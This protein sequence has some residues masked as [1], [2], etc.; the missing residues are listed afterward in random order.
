[1]KNTKLLLQN[2]AQKGLFRMR[3]KIQQIPFVSNSKFLTNAMH[4]TKFR[5]ITFY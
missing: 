4:I 2:Y 3:K 1:M 5:K